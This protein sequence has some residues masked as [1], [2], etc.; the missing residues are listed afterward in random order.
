MGLRH[1]GILPYGLR[2]HWPAWFAEFHFEH[3]YHAKIIRNLRLYV[4]YGVARIFAPKLKSRFPTPQA[5]DFFSTKF[6]Y[7]LIWNTSD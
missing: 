3:L 1:R 6:D 4:R 5:F 7:L 2:S